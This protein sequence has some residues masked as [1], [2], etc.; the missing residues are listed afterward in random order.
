MYTTSWV[1]IVVPLCL[2]TFSCSSVVLYHRKSHSCNH[3]FS[4]AYTN[5]CRKLSPLN[6]SCSW[7]FCCLL[8]IKMEMWVCSPQQFSSLW[9]PAL[10]GSS[11]LGCTCWMP[12]RRTCSNV[13]GCFVLHWNTF[14][15]TCELKLVWACESS[16]DCITILTW[17]C[18][19]K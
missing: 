19:N 1:F 11:G 17:H 4:K 9:S 3:G 6:D 16:P 15:C 2:T 10:W 18:E 8:Q 5:L 7:T 13:V 12:S 14:T